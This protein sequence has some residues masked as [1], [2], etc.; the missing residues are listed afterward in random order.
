M[1]DKI[2]WI[3]G[4]MRMVVV[5]VV[6]GGGRE[7]GMHPTH[8]MS[9]ARWGTGHSSALPHHML[10]QLTSKLGWRGGVVARVAVEPVVV[11]GRQSRWLPGEVHCTSGAQGGA[12]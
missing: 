10:G 1:G 11:V 8:A 3:M 7:V 2:N 9:V 4:I 6:G 12:R 5:V